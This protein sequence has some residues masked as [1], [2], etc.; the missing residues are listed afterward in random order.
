M[1]RLNRPH[2]EP[3]PE[4]AIHPS[5]V[6]LIDQLHKS[7]FQ[8]D[9]QGEVAIAHR[10]KL[11]RIAKKLPDIANRV[12]TTFRTL[13]KAEGLDPGIVTLYSVGGRVRGTP[14][15]EGTDF[16]VVIAAERRLNPFAKDSTMTIAQRH[17]IARSLY[18]KLPEIFASL[19]LEDDYEKGIIEIKGLGERTAAEVEREDAVLK[20]CENTD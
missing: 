17:A 3:V 4:N 7:G 14:I 13:A 2:A 5:V 8:E 1:D 12:L 15:K 6:F 20:I 16:D 19:G 10:E 9:F 18:T 11:E